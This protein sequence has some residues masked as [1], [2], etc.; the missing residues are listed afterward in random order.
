[1]MPLNAGVP[2]HSTESLPSVPVTSLR[3]LPVPV[4]RLSFS[5]VY[6]RLFFKA[7]SSSS[8]NPL[9]ALGTSIDVCASDAYINAPRRI[10]N[11]TRN[12][13]RLENGE[14]GN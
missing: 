7:I 1:M 6:T 9:K 3:A 10:V 13:S 2:V 11:K 14:N 8:W 5:I 12:T 4:N